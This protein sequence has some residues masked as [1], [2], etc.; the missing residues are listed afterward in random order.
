MSE[1][2]VALVTGGTDG[3]GKEI[4]RGLAASGTAVVIV[5]RSVAKGLAAQ[6]E[7]TASA[8]HDRVTFE[9]ADLSTVGGMHALADLVLD[10]WPQLRYL[11]HSA[12]IIR[13]YPSRTG[14]GIETNFAT[15][16][17]A[18]FVLTQRL[19]PALT[20]AG[21]PGSGARILLVGGAA[22]GGRIH[23]DDV[24]LESRFGLLRAVWQFQEANDV[25]TVELARRLAAEGQHTSVT[26][27]KIGVVKTAIRREFPWWTRW[28]VKWV[29]DPW[30]GQTPAEAATAGIHLLLDPEYEQESGMLFLKVGR[31]VRM[32]PGS[33]TVDPGI[34]RR[35]WRLSEQLEA[36]ALARPDNGSLTPTGI[37]L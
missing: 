32:T 33:G 26:C 12:G 34:G 3:I 11:V 14:D 8:G 20:A 5:G 36:T 7:L 30:I 13:S 4:A 27:I 29:F 16:Y 37:A 23:F 31:L 18:R 15:N 21:R 24:N 17:L 10:R 22:R 25:F 6:R 1:R 19:R 35:L 9:R 28:L 2:P